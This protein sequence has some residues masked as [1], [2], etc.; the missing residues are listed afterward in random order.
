MTGENKTRLNI[1]KKTFLFSFIF[2]LLIM[3]AAYVLT[4]VIPGGEFARITDAEGNRIIDVSGGFTEVQG[5]IPFWKWLFSPV[6]ILGASGSGTL[7]AVLLFHGLTGD[8]VHEG[9]D[10]AG[11]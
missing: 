7:I 3:V 10:D 9:H 11:H 2:M 5:G 6:L 1:G 8:D 4:M